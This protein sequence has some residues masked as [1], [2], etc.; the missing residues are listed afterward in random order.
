MA[1][2]VGAGPPCSRLPPGCAAESGDR[3]RTDHPVVTR[4]D[5]AIDVAARLTELDPTGRR[6]DGEKVVSDARRLAAV[7]SDPGVA[8]E[9]HA[10][11]TAPPAAGQP[12]QHGLSTVEDRL[13]AD[14][15]DDGRVGGEH[16]RKAPGV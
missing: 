13:C 1:G 9:M 14:S 5:K 6:L 15:Q 3:P 12:R 2:G 4:A 16:L 11:R 10:D 7:R 8:S